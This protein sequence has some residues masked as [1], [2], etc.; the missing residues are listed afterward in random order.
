MQGNILARAVGA[1]DTGMRKIVPFSATLPAGMWF[2]TN[3][4]SIR[5]VTWLRVASGMRKVATMSGPSNGGAKT[6]L[7]TQFP[8]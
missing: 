2:S 3:W 8:K 6:K 4:K 5:N 7:Q 1:D